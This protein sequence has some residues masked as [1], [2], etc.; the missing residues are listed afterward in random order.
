MGIVF[1][2]VVKVFFGPSA[3]TDVMLPEGCCFT[4][5]PAVVVSGHVLYRSNFSMPNGGAD[6]DWIV[7]FTCETTSRIHCWKAAFAHAVQI[8]T[9][10]LSLW[11]LLCFRFCSMGFPGRC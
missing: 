4:D 3:D 5:V 2:G 8:D 7:V 9:S 10:S 6:W 1:W 11:A